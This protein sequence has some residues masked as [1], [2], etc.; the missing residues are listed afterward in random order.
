M[1]DWNKVLKESI[2]TPEI[3]GGLGRKKKKIIH[4]P[5]SIEQAMAG[6]HTTYNSQRKATAQDRVMSKAFK[7]HAIETGKRQAKHAARV[8]D[9]NRFDFLYFLLFLGFVF[10]CGWFIT[11]LAGAK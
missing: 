4:T 2:G 11:L 10:A 3:P 6:V 8:K 9:P 1:T 5:P 7:Y